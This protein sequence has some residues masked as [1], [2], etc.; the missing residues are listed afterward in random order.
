MRKNLT[1]ECGSL[2]QSL[3]KTLRESAV[4]GQEADDLVRKLLKSVDKILDGGSGSVKAMEMFTQKNMAARGFDI[5]EEFRMFSMLSGIKTQVISPVSG[6]VMSHARTVEDTVGAYLGRALG[7]LTEEEGRQVARMAAVERSHIARAQLNIAEN[8][9]IWSG[10]KDGSSPWEKIANGKLEES[11]MNSAAAMAA[12]DRLNSGKDGFI[13]GG[14][15]FLSGVSRLSGQA[16][17]Q[18]DQMTKMIAGRARHIARSNE[19][20][21]AK[22]YDD[23]T[24]LRMAREQADTLL[25]QRGNVRNQLRTAL[26]HKRGNAPED[27]PKEL[28]D[29]LRRT[30]VETEQDI[31]AALDAI[32]DGIKAGEDA[33]FTHKIKDRN[34]L[35]KLGRHIQN[36]QQDIPALKL[37]MPFVKTPTN[38]ASETWERTFGAA[39]GGTEVLLRKLSGKTPLGE[40]LRDPMFDMARRLESLD[41]RVRARAMGEMSIGV[42]AVS[43]VVMLAGQNDEETGMPK[44]TGT[45]PANPR[46]AATWREAGWQPR[47][48]MVGGNYVSYDRL[49]PLSGAI[50]G[51]GA[52]LTAALGWASD[53]GTTARDGS[54]LF[55]GVA[56]A[57]GANITSK[58]WMR[59]L[60]EAAEV[61]ADP[62]PHTVER[63]MKNVA[64]S[65]VPSIIRDVANLSRE[66]QMVKDINGVSDAFLAKIPGLNNSVDDRRNFMGEKLRYTD[67]PGQQKWNTIMPFNISRIKDDVISRELS[68]L[69]QGFSMPSTKVYGVDL[70][71]AAYNQEN[72]QTAYDRLLELS[73]EVKVGGRT[74][75]QEIRRV[76]KSPEY[77]RLDSFDFEGERNPRTAMLT[78]SLN[79]YRKKARTVLLRENRTLSSDVSSRSKARKQ[80][81][82]GNGFNFFQQ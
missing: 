45:A 30:G 35:D 64:G 9:K 71:D 18:G 3:S 51:F 16:L 21:L 22:G 25:E 52:D 73:S 53:D 72:G 56:A 32:D 13:T 55:L 29:L 78:K 49:D 60:R 75:R 68:K 58:T 38:I 2:F 80:R 36:A 15:Q 33:T 47:S 76:I 23:A 67:V 11:Q 48:I 12:L 65:Y 26:V 6:A 77:Q 8:I 50:L 27:M 74:L 19:H 43:G 69:P 7:S 46:L 34:F 5:A 41:P 62:A 37:V 28:D 40:S 4:P 10:L 24:A 59:G 63:M 82:A 54:D 79:K 20:F 66:E 44:I 1:G 81:R 17:Q 42:T 61:A 70:K 39:L 14:L 31:T 57:L